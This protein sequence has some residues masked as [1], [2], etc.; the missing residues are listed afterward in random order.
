VTPAEAGVALV[1]DAG[2]PS[3]VTVL[4]GVTPAEA[5]VARVTDAD[6]L[7]SVTVPG[8]VTRV[9]VL[10]CVSGMTALTTM[11]RVPSGRGREDRPARPGFGPRVCPGSVR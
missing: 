11:I 1:T 10:T 6:L 9:T 4:A 8:G 2:L 3:S 7:S 5:G